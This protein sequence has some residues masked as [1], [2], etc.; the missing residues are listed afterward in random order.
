MKLNAFDR[1]SSVI[2]KMK[3]SNNVYIYGAGELGRDVGLYF[4]KIG[5][6]IV[7]YVVGDLYLRHH[8]CTVPE[9]VLYGI[10]VRK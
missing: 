10:P 3:K 1:N 7:G 5:I 8:G 9:L 4:C 2:S 6:T